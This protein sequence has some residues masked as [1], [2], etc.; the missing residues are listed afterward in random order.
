MIEVILNTLQIMLVIPILGVTIGYLEKIAGNFIARHIGVK[1]ALFIINKLT[2]VGVMHHELSHALFAFVSGAKI[3]EINLF[4]PQGNSLGSV[5]IVPRG[6][7]IL[8]S[9]QLTLTAIAPVVTGIIS[10]CTIAYFL[11]M[12]IE[13]M[14][15]WQIILIAYLFISIFFHSTMSTAD[16]KCAI[17]GLPVCTLI[18]FI[19]ELITRFNLV[20]FI[21]G[22][23]K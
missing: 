7:K 18:I 5:Q 22:I 13:N 11:S 1:S 8:K 2:F 10:M 3:K 23:L 6:N 17:N 16:L 9:I 4:K 20:E 15:V 19:V 14:L 12:N 21:G